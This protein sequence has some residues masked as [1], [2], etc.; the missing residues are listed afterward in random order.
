MA[1][2]KRLQIMIDED[3]DAALDR[4]ALEERTSKAALI[5]RFVREK[6]QPLPPLEEDPIWQMVGDIDVEPADIDEVL[7]GPVGDVDE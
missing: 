5:R 1:D 2:V 6:V 7:Y 3:L 4:M